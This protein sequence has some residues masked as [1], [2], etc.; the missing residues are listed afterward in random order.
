MYR[1]GK[2]NQY[3]YLV[4]L[5]LDFSLRIHIDTLYI[6]KFII[7][8][9]YLNF[10]YKKII[11]TQTS[12]PKAFTLVEVLVVVVM[13]WILSASIVS[14]LGNNTMIARDAARKVDL[15]T[16]HT[17][18]HTYRSDRGTFPLAWACLINTPCGALSSINPTTWVQ[19]IAWSYITKLP[20]DP[21]K[22]TEF[23][24]VP[25][26]TWLTYFYGMVYSDNSPTIWSGEF[27]WLVGRLENEN[28]PST[29]SQANLNNVTED[30]YLRWWQLMECTWSNPSM[31][32]WF[33]QIPY[34]K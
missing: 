7:L 28:D 1:K 18:I 14:K 25:W 19:W 5:S 17:A 15:R 21:W 22:S 4:L 23:G 13:I 26:L 31:A 32:K 6:S 16:V 9:T 33:Y 30:D 2:K 11:H 34:N 29:C 8:T 10:M 12:S 24:A 27:F 20:Q 3:S